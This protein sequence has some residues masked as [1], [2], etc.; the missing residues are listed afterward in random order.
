MDV[1]PSDGISTPAGERGMEERECNKYG[2]RRGR[3]AALVVGAAR[4]HETRMGGKHGD[5]PK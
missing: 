2:G 3:G 5:K 1:P 4:S